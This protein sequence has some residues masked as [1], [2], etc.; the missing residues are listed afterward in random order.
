M[1][2]QTM[3][4]DVLIAVG[5]NSS[6]AIGGRRPRNADRGHTGDALVAETLN[7][8]A[9]RGA[10]G[11]YPRQHDASTVHEVDA[12]I[13]RSSVIRPQ[14]GGRPRK[15]QLGI[16]P[17]KHNRLTTVGAVVQH[18]RRRGGIGRL[19]QRRPVGVTQCNELIS[20]CAHGRYIGAARSCGRANHHQAVGVDRLR[21]THAP[22]AGSAGST[23]A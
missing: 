16:G 10:P 14:S 22:E 20:P 4:L 17:G 3:G 12:L 6:A 1:Q 9:L 8:G 23:S 11:A 21:A 13:A 5:V 15:S 2:R 18:V 7:I 19:R